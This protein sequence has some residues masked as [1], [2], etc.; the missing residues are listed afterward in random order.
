MLQS[1]REVAKKVEE[2][3]KEDAEELDLI[4]VNI[5]NLASTINENDIKMFDDCEYTVTS[6]VK[7]IIENTSS[8]NSF[9]LIDIGAVIRRFKLWMMNMPNVHMY[10]AVK[11]NPDR[12][13]LSTLLH[14]GVGFDVASKEEITL[15]K[16]LGAPKD[17]IIFANPVKEMSH[18]SYAE[19][20]EV[21]L[22]TFDSEDELIKIKALHPKA[23]LVLRILVDD[24]KS[25]MPFGYK[26]GCPGTNLKKVLSLAKTL[27]LKIVG[28]SFHVGSGCMDP[29]AYSDAISYS[30][31]VF[32]IAKEE[33]F[34][35]SL[36]DIGGGFPG[37]DNKSSDEDFI[38]IAKIVKDEIQNSFADVEN[39]QV[40]AEPGRFFATSAG[41]LATNVIGRKVFHDKDD[42][43][44]FHYYVNSNIYGLFNNIVFDKAIVSFCLLKGSEE[45]RILPRDAAMIEQSDV[46]DDDENRLYKS[47]IFGQSCDSLDE[48]AP[49]IM[50]PEL[51]IGNWMY[52]KDQGAYS[53]ASASKFNGFELATV[54]YIFKY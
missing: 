48:I 41:I 45:Y 29:T 13:I 40:I 49:N 52:V 44:I 51:V 3:L 22:M 36:L 18:I 34:N 6:I 50:L 11:C 33:G 39:L 54:K 43:K 42:N 28:V 9:F 16:S 10:Y 21:S 2:E 26:F 14:L 35:M 5:E 20:E 15:V 31:R 8:L 38:K 1:G 30:R 19:T 37:H 24:S 23:K 7:K 32:D 25:K 27:H 53:I 4:G 17:K 46:S 12:M 47:V